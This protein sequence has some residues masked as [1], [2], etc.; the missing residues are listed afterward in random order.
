MPKL[1][2]LT[3]EPFPARAAAPNADGTASPLATPAFN[4]AAASDRNVVLYGP[5]SEISPFLP[6]D[7]RSAIT[8]PFVGVYALDQAPGQFALVISGVTPEEVSQAVRSFTH[9]NFPYVDAPQMV[10]TGITPPAETAG[11]R[12]APIMPDT[13]YSFLDLG[14]ASDTLSFAGPEAKTVFFDVPSDFYVKE[15][16]SLEVDLD[17]TYGAGFREDS[18]LN[19]VLNGRFQ[20]A[21]PLND[22]E[23][24][25]LRDYQLFLPARLLTPG[26]NTLTFAPV[27]LSNAAG[28][29]LPFQDGN[30]MVTILDRSELTFPPAES[31]V[32]QPDLDIFRRSGFPYT[33]DL[34]GEATTLVV[35]GRD[36]LTATAAFLLSAKLA[37]THGRVMTDMAVR[38]APEGEDI[39]RN[40]LVVGT[41]DEIDPRYLEDAPIAS[42]ETLR[43]AYAD[44]GETGPRF[45]DLWSDFNAAYDNAR[46]R[47]KNFKGTTTSLSMEQEA[48]LGRNA[49]LMAYRSPFSNK[50]R[51][52]T[53]ATAETTA[54]LSAGIQ[55]L[56][57]PAL[58]GQL[59]GDLNL[60]RPGS[61][62]V[63]SQQAGDLYYMGSAKPMSFLRYHLARAPFWWIFGALAVVLLLAWVIHRM[64]TSRAS[65][66]EDE[67]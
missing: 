39:G 50:E 14:A 12:L 18:V 63:Y 13:T 17:F 48:S 34:E 64:V 51:T 21:I 4:L 3:A 24:A 2:S 22:P 45:A 11:N 31:Y 16:D 57:E 49:V 53:V 38:Y 29:C 52:V 23:G 19:I 54:A 20:K 58:W 28:E 37:Q 15:S 56:M 61:E 7:V 40:L 67:A 27:M 5:R 43:L 35:A 26:P 25:S 60:W 44:T 33:G 36:K 59:A 32:H 8:G 1:R 46:G 62:F 10:V 47:E 42:G 9:Y 65:A 41:L 30:L 66:Y 6:A 55:Q